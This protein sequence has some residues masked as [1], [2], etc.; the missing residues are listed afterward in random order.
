M[1][2]EASACESGRA[3]DRGRRMGR[4][5]QSGGMPIKLRSP[6]YTKASR[7]RC[8]YVQPQPQSMLRLRRT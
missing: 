3:H 4:C 1:E 6:V 2:K 5:D 8:E 7:C